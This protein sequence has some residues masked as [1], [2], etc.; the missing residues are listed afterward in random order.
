MSYRDVASKQVLIWACTAMGARMPVAMAPL[1]LVFL[2]R[3]RPGGYALGAVLAAAYVV[4]EIVG[5]PV[6]GM[7]LC[8]ERARPHLAVGLAAGAAGFAGLGALPDASVSLLAVFAFLAGAAPGA[9]TGGLRAL[10][11]DLVPERAAAQALSVESI[12]MSGVWAVSPVAVAS[13]ALGVA[14]RAPLLLAAALMASSV[15]GLWL[16]PAGWKTDDPQGT[17]WAGGARLRILAGAWPVYV[18]GAA[19]LTLLGLAEL[20]PPA[21]LEQRGIAVGWSAP[22]AGRD[23]GGRGTGRLPLRPDGLARFGRAPACSACAGSVLRDPRRADSGLGRDRRGLTVSPLLQ[24]AAAGHRQP[25][26]PPAPPANVLAAGS[27]VMYAAG[28]AARDS[29]AGRPRGRPLRLAAAPRPPGR[30]GPEAVRRAGGVPKPP[31]FSAARRPCGLLGRTP[32]PLSASLDRGTRRRRPGTFAISGRPDPRPVCRRGPSTGGAEAGLAGHR[33]DGQLGGLQQ[34]PARSTRCWVSH[35]PRLTPTSPLQRPV[36][37]RTDMASC[38][39]TARSWVGSWSVPAPTVALCREQSATTVRSLRLG[40]GLPPGRRRSGGLPRRGRAGRLRGVRHGLVRVGRA[41]CGG[42]ADGAGDPAEA[43][44]HAG[45]GARGGLVALAA[46]WL[47][48][49]T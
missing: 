11:T 18:T 36:K 40:T 17:E 23:G 48:W 6:L 3:E 37:G 16:L 25:S 9:A 1:A 45:A 24:P 20:V 43:D 34:V 28:G 21:L 7:R 44:D 38:S 19:S 22:V 30:R 46:Q 26:P 15:A 14:P 39:S 13:L 32:A 29:G 2:V 41:V 49:P 31:P 47:Q 4:G 35:W 12:L 8:P 42:G 27:S 5:A 10:L 33:V